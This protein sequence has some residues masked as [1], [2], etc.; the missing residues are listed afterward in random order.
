MTGRMETRDL[1]VF[2]TLPDRFRRR[3]VLTPWSKLNRL[4][5]P[6]HSFLEGPVAGP[7]GTLFVSD[8]EYGRVFRIDEDGGWELVAEFDGEPLGMIF[9]APGELLV[10][11]YRNGLAV[12]DVATGS[13]TPL[14]ERHGT[15]RFKGLNDLV[16][17]HAGNLYLTDQGETGLHDP[18][19]RVYRLDP[20]GRL[21]TLLA[22]VPGPNGLVLS[23]D[24]RV[25]YIAATRDNAV[26]RAPLMEDGTVTKVG[27]FFST[28]G[29][30]GPDGLAMDT[31]GR[32]AVAN[33]GRGVVWV[34]DHLGDPVFAL[35][36]PNGA[37][38]TNITHGGTD[39]TTLYCTEAETGTI[40][41][42]RVDTAGCQPW[43]SLSTSSAR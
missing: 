2:T 31:A 15:E 30:A 3:G 35:H 5:V 13:A 11:D 14:L 40:L 26:W 6:G 16:F 34:L 8:A 33:P 24:E 42:G 9:R 10:A 23:P 28:N 37:L 43:P 1:E 17:D 39:R 32:L 22:N 38:V 12:I 25:L 36:S 19:G 29:P 7:D 18:S 4:G 27:R 20:R 21:D 41:R